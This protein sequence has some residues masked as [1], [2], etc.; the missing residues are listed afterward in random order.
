[1]T[2]APSPIVKDFD[3]VEDIGPGQIPSFVDA[4]ADALLFQTADV[5]EG[6]FVC[7]ATANLSAIPVF[8][9]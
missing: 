6:N 5:V 2:V 3:V 8:I 4:L 9:G 1:M 7:N